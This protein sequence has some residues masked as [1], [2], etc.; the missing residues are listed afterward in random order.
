MKKII[1]K[2]NEKK[3]INYLFLTP[4]CNGSNGFAE[5]LKP[6]SDILVTPHNKAEE[7][8]N[9]L[10][11]DGIT[12]KNV[13]FNNS[14]VYTEKLKKIFC[15]MGIKASSYERGWFPHS[16][17]HFDPDGFSHNSLLAKSRLD[18]IEINDKDVSREIDFYKKSINI[19]K[20]TLDIPDKY[21][22]VIM[23]HTNDATIVHGYPEFSGWQSIIDYADKLRKKDEVLLIKVHPQ[24]I[25]ES[26]KIPSN[27][28]IV[29]SKLYNNSL[30]EK[31]EVVIGVNSTM[32]YEASLIFNRPVVA[33][34]ESWF[35]GHREVVYKTKIGDLNRPTVSEDDI[36]YRQKMFKIMT[37]MQLK[38]LSKKGIID[39]HEKVSKI[40]KIEDWFNL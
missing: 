7:N 21:I 12:I 19:G 24:N 13:I 18:K 28:I 6:D 40:S 5:I 26:I 23:Q 20:K 14:V 4:F 2:Y 9:K 11:D 32:L 30:L 27:S 29:N 16:S 22:I 35:N 34:G 25:N 10:F 31:A 8:I 36:R 3:V 39:M 15:N 33:L 38:D 37:K 17:W 1:L